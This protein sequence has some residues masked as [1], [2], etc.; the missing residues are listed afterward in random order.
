MKKIFFSTGFTVGIIVIF[1]LV[2]YGFSMRGNAGNPTTQKNLVVFSQATFPFESSHERSTFSQVVSIVRDHRLNFSKKLADFSVPDVAYLKGKFYSYF[3]PGVAFLIMPLYLLGRSV[4]MSQFISYATIPIVSTASLIFL[5]LIAVNVLGFPKR[6][7]VFSVFLYAFSS[8]AWPYSITIYQHIPAVF[9]ILSIFYFAWLFRKSKK[10]SWI[11][12]TVIWFE[13]GISFLFDYPNPILLFPVIIYFFISS[14]TIR[15]N[16][17]R[18]IIRVNLYTCITSIIFFIVMA[19]FAIYNIKAYGNWKML[20]NNLPRY[21]IKNIAKL[22]KK[23]VNTKYTTTKLAST[24]LEERLP[25]GFYELLIAPDKG[26]LVF[27]PVFIVMIIGIYT[28]FKKYKNLEI[29][30]LG[31]IVFVNFLL[32][33]SFGD[34]WGGWAFGPRYLI[35]SMSVGS[36]FVGIF[37]RKYWRSL[38]VRIAM[39]VLIGISSAIALLGVLT[40]NALPPKVEATYLHI[41]YGIPYAF[42]YL[43]K[44][45]TDNFIFNTFFSQRITLFQYFIGMYALIMFVFFALFF[46][47]NNNIYEF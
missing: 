37:L 31:S 22:Q 17:S 46:I 47:K 33:S 38:Y 15:K 9:L 12:A 36:L 27:S 24:F 5:Y 19:G 2:I 45:I 20:S 14:V 16:I 6:F 32:Y 13:F 18:F 44:G 8:T 3:P 39:L 41:Q 25:N 28:A 26:L 23:I 40:T 35:P 30:I 21:E 4:H 11:W 1:S 42:E 34:P 7:A 29:S 10:N 43:R